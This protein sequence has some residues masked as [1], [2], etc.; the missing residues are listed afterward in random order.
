MIQEENP[1]ISSEEL[2]EDEAGDCE[3]ISFPVQQYSLEDEGDNGSGKPTFWE[4]CK[5]NMHSVPRE[6]KR[7]QAE[8]HVNKYSMVYAF[9]S[10]GTLAVYTSL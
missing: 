7:T 10:L 9:A 1:I 5:R 3:I 2:Q 8:A 4:W 6:N